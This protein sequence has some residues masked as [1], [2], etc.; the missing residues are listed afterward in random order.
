MKAADLIETGI[1]LVIGIWVMLVAYGRIRAPSP[2][3][4]DWLDRHRRSA[5]I[6]ATVML[7]GIAGLVILKLLG[8]QG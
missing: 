2:E 1:I 6:L 4:G 3:L 5:K 8:V 7:V